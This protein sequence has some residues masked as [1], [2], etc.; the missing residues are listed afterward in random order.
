[1]DRVLTLDERHRDGM[2][3]VD[4]CLTP[5]SC[6]MRDVGHGHQ[7]TADERLN[8]YTEHAAAV[9]RKL[10]IKLAQARGARR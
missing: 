5:A 2:L 6:S 7:M 8:A 1:M 10:G 4:R 9:G 3:I